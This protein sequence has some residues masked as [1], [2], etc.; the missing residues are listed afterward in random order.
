MRQPASQIAEKC[1]VTEATVYRWISQAGL[2]RRPRP[3][4]DDATLRHLYVD[5]RL[6]IRAIAERY[7]TSQT[8]TYW[9]L[10]DAETPMR[11]PGGS[12]V[13][14]RPDDHQLEDLYARQ[15]M[16]LPDLAKLI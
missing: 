16:S 2:R 4:P 7:D 1:S 13:P 9:W 11:Q 8:T 15:G 5:I 6:N 3:R 10:I 12:E 14:I